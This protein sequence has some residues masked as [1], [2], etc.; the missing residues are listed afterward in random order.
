MANA[1]SSITITYSDSSAGTTP[2]H[3]VVF[4]KDYCNEAVIP[5]ASIVISGPTPVSGIS[6]ADGQFDAGILQP[7]NYTMTLS[8]VDYLSN[9]D[10]L[11]ANDSFTV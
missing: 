2:R 10:D 5:S 7:G 3:V 6:D 9:S 11:L 4:V 1:S 8:A